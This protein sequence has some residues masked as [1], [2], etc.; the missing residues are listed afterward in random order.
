L[1]ASFDSKAVA[2]LLEVFNDLAAELGLQTAA[3]REKAAKI[4][5]K[6]AQGQSD[7]DAA[8][9]RTEATALMRK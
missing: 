3:E 8:K 2:V 7:L 6:I 5:I 9:L 1:A 4:I